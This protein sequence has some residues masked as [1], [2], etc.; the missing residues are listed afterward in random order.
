MLKINNLQAK[1][2]EKE[3]LKGINFRLTSGQIIGIVGKSGAGKTS[4]LK[5]MSGL[6]DP[7]AGEILFEN[8]KVLGPSVKLVPGHAE[9]QL[10]NQDFHLEDRKSVV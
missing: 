6:L 7:T 5:I 10:V 3:I 2:G 1:I 4:F 8:K 9:I